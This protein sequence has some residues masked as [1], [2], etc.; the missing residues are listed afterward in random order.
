MVSFGL[1]VVFR[2]A[3]ARVVVPL[4]SLAYLSKSRDFSFPVNFFDNILSLL[5]DFFAE[6]VVVW[7]PK[8]GSGLSGAEFLVIIVRNCVLNRPDLLNSAEW[9]HFKEILELRV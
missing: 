7:G 6:H 3:E 2:Q 4:V 1:I 8:E 5:S 9:L